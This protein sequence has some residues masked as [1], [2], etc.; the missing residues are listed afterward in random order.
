M[1]KMYLKNGL[2]LNAE[3]FEYEIHE[4]K[5]EFSTMLNSI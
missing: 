4:T 2:F 5:M 3:I 1:K